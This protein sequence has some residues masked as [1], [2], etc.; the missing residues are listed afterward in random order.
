MKLKPTLISRH[1]V[2][3][4]LA[5]AASTV[6]LQAQ[7]TIV[8]PS[9]TPIDKNDAGVIQY[10]AGEAFEGRPDYAGAAGA[11]GERL[12][13]N[14]PTQNAN[15]IAV[16]RDI[17]GG[18]HSVTKAPYVALQRFIL[19]VCGALPGVSSRV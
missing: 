12:L 18:A 10:A 11:H 2:G 13:H 4:L 19:D 14:A 1:L 9:F 6:A 16:D 17:K 5:L 15:E 3:L 7:D 8:Q